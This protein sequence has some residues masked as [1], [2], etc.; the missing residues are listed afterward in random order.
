MDGR[1]LRWEMNSSPSPIR[2]L[3]IGS[4]SL[5]LAA[6]SL[7]E[8]LYEKIRRGASLVQLATGM[9]FEGPQLIGELNRGLA[10]LLRRDGYHSVAEAVGTAHQTT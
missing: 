10:A 9:I 5:R 2:R 3:R 7:P 6:C 8:D 4:S 1:R